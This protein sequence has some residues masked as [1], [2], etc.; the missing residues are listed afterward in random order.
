MS[1]YRPIPCAQHSEYE[2]LA[3]HHT[4]VQI[5][6]ADSGERLAGTIAD[7]SVREGAEYIL[8]DQVNEQIEIRMDRIAGVSKIEK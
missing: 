3:M 6:L 5:T 4:P 7:I 1:D 2:L 8:L